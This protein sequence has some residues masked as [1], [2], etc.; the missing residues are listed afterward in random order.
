VK[1]A[2]VRATITQTIHAAQKRSAIALVYG[3]KD[4]EHN[5]AIVLQ[6]IF[7]RIASSKPSASKALES[8]SKVTKAN[9]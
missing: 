7:K 4:T 6:R 3:A 1:N 8:R 9:A 2:E 5:E